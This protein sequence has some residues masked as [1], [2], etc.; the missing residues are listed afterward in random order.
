MLNLPRRGKRKPEYLYGW[1]S[2][3]GVSDADVLFV[4][5]N[6]GALT[7]WILSPGARSQR[8]RDARTAAN[9]PVISGGRL[10][11]VE[12]VYYAR[13]QRYLDTLATLMRAISR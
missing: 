1:R 5:L 12:R 6:R 13:W 10:K 11:P 4:H 3:H 7:S 8:R 2:L 9:S